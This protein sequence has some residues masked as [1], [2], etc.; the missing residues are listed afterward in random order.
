MPLRI[1]W[2]PTVGGQIRAPEPRPSNVGERFLAQRPQGVVRPPGDLAGDRQSGAVSA[3]A[4]GD[5]AVVGA[6][7][8]ISFH[9]GEGLPHTVV[10]VL[11]QNSDRILVVLNY[12]PLFELMSPLE[13]MDMLNALFARVDLRRAAG[14]RSSPTASAADEPKKTTGIPS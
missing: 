2:R 11:A 13:R 9:A 10:A 4:V 5:S 1:G 12:S 14:S 6:L 8:P 3:E 7:M